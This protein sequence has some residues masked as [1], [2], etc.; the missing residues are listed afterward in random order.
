MSNRPDKSGRW[1]FP[2][3]VPSGVSAFKPRGASAA[4]KWRVA[5]RPFRGAKRRVE[6]VSTD[7]R[8]TYRR[9]LEIAKLIHEN[10]VNPRAARLAAAERKPVETHLDEYERDL[11]AAGVTPHHAYQVR[12]RCARVFKAAGITRLSEILPSPVNSAIAALKDARAAEPDAPLSA[13]TRN[14]YLRALKQF[15]A[16]LAGPEKRAAEDLLKHLRAL[17]V[18]TDRRHDRQDLGDAAAARLIEAARTGPEVLGLAGADRAMLYEAAI[19][20]GL[21]ANELATLTPARCQLEDEHPVLIVKAGYAKGRREDHQPIRREFAQ[22]L[23]AY[24]AGRPA[25]EP[26]WKVPPEPIDLLRDYRTGAGDLDRAG[27]PYIDAEGRFAD[28][29]ALRHTF[30]CRLVRAGVHPKECQVLARH[31]SIT[32]TMNY[33]AHLRLSDTARAIGQMAALPAAAAERA[34][35]G[36]HGAQAQM[37]RP[38]VSEC[39]P[40]S[41]KGGM[42][43]GAARSV[44]A[45]KAGFSGRQRGRGAMHLAGVEPATFGSVDPSKVSP[46]PCLSTVTRAARLRRSAGRSAPG[47]A[48]LARAVNSIRALAERDLQK[49]EAH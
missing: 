4:T 9:A 45:A 3:A 2:F 43:I 8:A 46:K 33:Y 42:R 49:R 1:R 6:H 37:K 17:N 39:L 31:A 27:I 20:S 15:A 19:E 26:I 22:R 18:K 23:A 13:Q 40:V 41:D 21:R 44:S 16:W 47:P 29:H 14:H 7:A 10:E 32:T 12:S 11:L 5:F 48:D 28:F 35:T 38:N 36:T 25:A 30:V 34:A 24:L